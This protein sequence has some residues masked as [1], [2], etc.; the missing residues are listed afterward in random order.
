MAEYIKSLTENDST[1][2][3]KENPAIHYAV[4][5]TAA[6]T[7]AKTV[8]IEGFKLDTGSWLA[9]KFT[10]TNTGAVGSLTLNVNGT[11][12]YAIKYRNGNLGSAS[13]L[14]ANRIYLFLFDGTY[15]Q[16][17]GD[18]NTNDNTYDRTYIQMRIYASGVGVFPYSLCAATASGTNS[19]RM[20]AFTATGGNGTS[21]AFNTSARFAYP[22]MIFYHSANSTIAAGSV[23]ANGA[24]YEQYPSVNL[25][26]SCNITTSAGFAQYKPVF[27]ECA[28][29]DDHTWSITSTGLTQ[30]FTAGKY[31]IFLGSM[32]STSIYQLGLPAQHPMYYY[33]GT[34]LNGVIFDTKNTAGATDTSSKIYLVGATEQTANP[35]TYSDDEVFTTS[36]VLT[37]KKVQVG[38][39]SCTME[40]NT[41]TESL[42]FVFI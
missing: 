13:Y 41:T 14:A 23:I 38:G 4:C 28:M 5:S 16:I 42:D 33:D 12:A 22:P 1:Y 34:N 31:Y 32:Y 9:I 7:T 10:V 37:T 20:E 39:G 11:G 8:D 35:Q 19:V 25:T 26:Y 29:N 18:I 30:T 2:L 17:V 36:G 27:L 3:I 6:A 24:L 40:Y 21:K 15:W